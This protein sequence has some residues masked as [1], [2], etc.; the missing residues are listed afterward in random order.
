MQELQ[1]AKD[2]F[3]RE[4]CRQGCPG[5]SQRPVLSGAEAIH[6]LVT[7]PDHVRLRAG[8]FAGLGD[9]SFNVIRLAGS[10]TRT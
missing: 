2:F 6:Q 1:D 10:S 7:G 3:L 9:P 4:A 8:G 5:N